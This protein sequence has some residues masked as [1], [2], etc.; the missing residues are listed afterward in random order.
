MHTYIRLFQY[1][2]LV[3]TYCKHNRNQSI[4]HT[5]RQPDLVQIYICAHMCTYVYVYICL[6]ELTAVNGRNECFSQM[7]FFLAAKLCCILNSRFAI[8]RACVQA[9]CAGELAAL[10]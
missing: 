4:A 2:Y 5:P 1:V 9:L 3:Y 7:L 10:I 8:H 6:A